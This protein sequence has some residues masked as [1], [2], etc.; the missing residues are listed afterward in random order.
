[1]LN[2][3][4]V[5]PVSSEVLSLD[6]ENIPRAR[7]FENSPNARKIPRNAKKVRT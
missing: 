3:K 2:E 7:G 6:E 4:N 1:M 5:S